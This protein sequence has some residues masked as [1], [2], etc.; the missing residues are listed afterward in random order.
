MRKGFF[1]SVIAL[2]TGL[3]L[4]GCSISIPGPMPESVPTVQTEATGAVQTEAAGEFQIRP[5]EGEPTDY[6]VDDNWM[7]LV[8]EPDKDVDLFYIY[9]T[10]YEKEGGPDLSDVDDPLV[11][12]L[13]QLVYSKTGSAIGAP[14][15]V[16]APYYRQTNLCKAME[17]SYDEY[18]EFNMGLQRTDIYAALDEYF[19][20]YNNGR[21]FILAGHSQGS[22]LI[23]IIL[24]EYMQAHPQYLDRM[25]AAYAVGFAIT[26]DWLSEHPYL[27]TPSC[28]LP[29][30][31]PIPVSS[32]PGTRRGQATRK[33]E[34]P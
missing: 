2:M 16:Y 33:P 22:C 18:T 34:I 8:K 7:L 19:E 28:I 14:T 15:N 4:A 5:L 25:I 10:V 3:M 1:K 9:P 30:A 6:T 12:T 23:K 17:L 27:N 13:A 21:P 29:R 32:F 24:G 31:R 26:E 20:K 11:R